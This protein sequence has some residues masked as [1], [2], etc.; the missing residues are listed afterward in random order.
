MRES[1]PTRCG[2][3]IGKAAVTGARSQRQLK[4]AQPETARQAGAAM[5]HLSLSA[6]GNSP[7]KTTRALTTRPFFWRVL[8][9]RQNP[10]VT[11]LPN[12]CIAIL[13]IGG[14]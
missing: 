10:A 6:A 8:E 3:G 2:F 5:R 4:A 7:A 9:A 1:L 14:K 12:L 13:G 11:A